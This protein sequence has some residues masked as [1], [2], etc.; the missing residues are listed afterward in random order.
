MT[1]LGLELLNNST[2]FSNL[3]TNTLSAL[4]ELTSATTYGSVA[5]A[6]TFNVNAVL[7][8][9]VKNVDAKILNQP[10]L[11][12]KDNEEAIFF[13]GKYIAFLR[14]NQS[15]STGQGITNSYDYDDVGVTLRVRPNITPEKAVDV[16]I[17]LE[18]SQVE[19]DEINDQVAIN[20]LNTT[21]SLIVNDGETIMLGGILFQTETDIRT[22]V[23]LIGDIPIIGG[24]FRHEDTVQSNNELLV[25]I[26]PYVI[27]GPETKSETIEQI[28]TPKLKMKE[29]ADHLDELFKTSDEDKK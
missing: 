24:A 29:V 25:F 7:D 12:T 11:W 17:N 28:E 9:L 5:A 14:E 13:K 16:T 23:P 3:G 20:K 6:Y 4:A 15:D 21:T 26:T 27:D 2:V 10:T 19:P 22:K 18:I 1:S 8:V